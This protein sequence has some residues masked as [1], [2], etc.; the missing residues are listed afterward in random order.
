MAGESGAASGGGKSSSGS[1]VGSGRGSGPA[2]A[3]TSQAF[4]AA[5]DGK[6]IE[7]KTAVSLEPSVVRSA[8]RLQVTLSQPASPARDFDL[9]SR[10]ANLRF[11]IAATQSSQ[12]SVQLPKVDAAK[13]TKVYVSRSDGKRYETR[14]AIEAAKNV[15]RAKTANQAV[16]NSNGKQQAAGKVQKHVAPA[17]SPSFAPA[18]A[19]RGVSVTPAQTNKTPKPAEGLDKTKVMETYRAAIE[20][21][22]ARQAQ[23]Q[24]HS[25]GHGR[26]GA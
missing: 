15:D 3:S 1:G 6:S 2:A 24:N 19:K 16:A 20:M 18:Q 17:P 26:S 22:A 5:R 4:A 8:E 9:S 11:N 21:A 14:Q 7:K 23:A 25:R 13:K 12:R 10:S